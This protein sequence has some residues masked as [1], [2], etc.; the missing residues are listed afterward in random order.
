MGNGFS[1]LFVQPLVLRSLKAIRKEPA[2]VAMVLGR[3]TPDPGLS[4]QVELPGG[5]AGG[6]LDLIGIGKALPS[7]SIAA[8]Q[9]PPALLQVQ[10]AGAFGNEDLLEPRMLGQPCAGLGTVVAGEV[11]SDD[12]NVARRIVGFDVSEQGNVIRRVARGGALGQFLAIAYT[13]RSIHPGFLRTATV[14]HER[15]NAMPIGRPTRGWGEGTWHYWPQFVGADGR[16]PV[17]RRGVVADD[18]CSFGTKSASELSPQLC[19]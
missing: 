19:V 16:R 12:E 11:V 15:F 10:P 7:Q 14:I 17:G 4:P 18:R 1:G 2:V 9:A 5:D 8:E 13:Q 6:L 3:P